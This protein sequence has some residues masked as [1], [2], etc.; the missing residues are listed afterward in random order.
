MIDWGFVLG[1]FVP[2]AVAAACENG[3]YTVVWRTSLGI[4]VLF[5]MFLFVLRIFIK[6]PEEFQRNSMRHAKTPYWLALRFYGGRL[7]CIS[8]IWFI[9]DV[10]IIMLVWCL[11]FGLTAEAYPKVV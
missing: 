11:P 10:S 7:F 4:G 9:Y 5:P 2:F 8:L 6:E 3:H 1:A